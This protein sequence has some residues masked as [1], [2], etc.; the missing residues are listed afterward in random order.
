MATGDPGTIRG[1]GDLL[2]GILL[3]VVAGGPV[4]QLDEI[5]HASYSRAGPDKVQGETGQR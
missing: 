2:V 5:F 3:A 1:C 4:A